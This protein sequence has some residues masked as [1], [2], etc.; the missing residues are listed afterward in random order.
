ML[1]S[2]FAP[3]LLLLSPSP[4]SYASLETKGSHQPI[5]HASLLRDLSPNDAPPQ[6]NQVCS[7][8]LFVCSLPVFL[9]AALWCSQ[10]VAH[11]A[12]ASNRSS[13]C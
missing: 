2:F 13:M 9:S 3:F 5:D 10:Q 4:P 11:L 6:K 7:M 1:S 8:L 12:A